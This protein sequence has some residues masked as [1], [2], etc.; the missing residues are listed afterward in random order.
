MTMN[1]ERI[2]LLARGI[3]SDRSIKEITGK[4]RLVMLAFAPYMLVTARL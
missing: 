2:R 1:H 4:V 3:V